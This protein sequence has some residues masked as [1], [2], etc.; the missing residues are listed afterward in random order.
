MDW[1]LGLAGS[2]TITALVI[3]G[4]FV[5][6]WLLGKRAGVWIIAAVTVLLGILFF[7]FDTGRGTS[8]EV[9]ALLGA[10]WAVAPVIAALIGRRLRGS[11]Q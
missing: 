2:V 5:Y 8:T 4:I 10:L 6:P 11:T 9:S 7:Y 1:S 3:L